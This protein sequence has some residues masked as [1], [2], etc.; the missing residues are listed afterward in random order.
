MRQAEVPEALW[1]FPPG[2]NPDSSHP[3]LLQAKT[4]INEGRE[5]VRS[6]RVVRLSHRGFSSISARL[7]SMPATAKSVG[8]QSPILRSLEQRREEE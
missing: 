3:H 7:G 5:W 6:K 1:S 8:L 2:A 4:V